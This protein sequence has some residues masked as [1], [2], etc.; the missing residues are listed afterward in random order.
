MKYRH[1]IFPYISICILLWHRTSG[2]QSPIDFPLHFQPRA[3][4]V[5]FRNALQKASNPGRQGKR[6]RLVGHVI[7]P[8]YQ[9]SLICDH[10]LWVFAIWI[11]M[12]QYHPDLGTGTFE[13][14]KLSKKMGWESLSC[15]P[16]PYC[17]HV[18]GVQLSFFLVEP[19]TNEW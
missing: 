2:P 4:R 12:G 7:L 3:S 8:N 16:T 18:S 11:H 1:K 17:F 13:T 15:D 14:A 10:V 19:A 5:P 6:L 9:C